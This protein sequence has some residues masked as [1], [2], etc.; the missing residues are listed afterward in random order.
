MNQS[1]LQKIPQYVE[2]PPKIEVKHIVSSF[3][4]VFTG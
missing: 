2:V 1:D 3:S 4:A